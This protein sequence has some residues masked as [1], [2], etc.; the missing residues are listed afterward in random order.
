MGSTIFGARNYKASK[1]QEGDS[2]DKDVD[3]AAKKLDETSITDSAVPL[4]WI[5][6]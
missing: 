1:P 6:Y 2:K 3:Q 4:T 5:F